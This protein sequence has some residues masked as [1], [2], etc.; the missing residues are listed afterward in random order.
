MK[1]SWL[2]VRRLPAV[3]W[4]SAVG[5][6]VVLNFVMLILPTRAWSLLTRY[7]NVA[8]GV[9]VQRS[10]DARLFSGF[11]GKLDVGPRR[12]QIMRGPGVRI[13]TRGKSV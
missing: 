10:L 4:K 11:R 12:L 8:I 6:S 2:G 9:L 5:Y 13:A 7:I 1:G 3:V